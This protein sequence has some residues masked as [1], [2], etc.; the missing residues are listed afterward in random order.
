MRGV[1][2]SEGYICTPDPFDPTRPGYRG[3]RVFVNDDPSLSVTGW[4]LTVRPR[5]AVVNGST[6]S[7]PTFSMSVMHSTDDLDLT[8]VVKVPSSPG[9]GVDQAF[10]LVAQAE[11]AA[12]TAEAIAQGLR[13]DANAGVFDGAPGTP[14]APGNAT[15]RLEAGAWVWD[16]AGAT[17]YLLPDETGALVARATPGPV[18]NPAKPEINW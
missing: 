14:G 3:I 10:A 1:F 17:N 2:D 13:D 16:L 6:P 8:N 11:A 18:P 9:V 4:T 12:V 15:I 5:F 7:I